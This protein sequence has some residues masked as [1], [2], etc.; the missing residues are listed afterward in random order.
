LNVAFR[1]ITVAHD[2][3]PAIVQALASM[4]VNK[5]RDF[6]FNRVRKQAL[7]SAPKNLS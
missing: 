3:R 4:G 5:Y 2:P 7:R 6:R 1:Q